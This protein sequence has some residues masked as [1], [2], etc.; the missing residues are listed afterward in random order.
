[1]GDKTRPDQT[2]SVGDRDRQVDLGRGQLFLGPCACARGGVASEILAACIY[3][4]SFSCA[5]LAAT[6]TPGP[7]VTL[8]HSRTE[9]TDVARGTWDVS[10]NFRHCLIRKNFGFFYYCSTFVFI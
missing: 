5:L 4:P 3:S 2:T 7:H 8:G 6:E 9:P 10:M 1:M